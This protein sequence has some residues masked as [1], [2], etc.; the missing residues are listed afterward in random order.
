MS[1]YHVRRG[2]LDDA[3]ILARHRNDMFKD[4]GV[5]LNAGVLAGEF[6]AWLRGTM[7]AGLYHAWVVETDEGEIVA[8]GG[9][10]VIPWPP[11][12]PVRQDRLRV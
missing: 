12:L 7:P 11:A 9:M 4:M 6:I 3:V 2:T 10:T 1:S 8:G 5:E